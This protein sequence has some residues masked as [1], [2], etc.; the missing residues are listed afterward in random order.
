MASNFDYILIVG[1]NLGLKWYIAGVSVIN[2][3]RVIFYAFFM[4]SVEDGGWPQLV[5]GVGKYF[6]VAPFLLVPSS[7]PEFYL[8]LLREIYQILS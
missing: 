6:T 7:L 8:T 5:S 4:L 1:D 2:L 3:L